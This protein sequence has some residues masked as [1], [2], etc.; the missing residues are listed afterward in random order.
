MH[1]NFKIESPS[2]SPI[3]P[4][5]CRSIFIHSLYH[6]HYP[7][8][9][10]QISQCPLNHLPRHP[11]KCFLHINKSHPQVFCARYFSCSCRTMMLLPAINAN[12]NFHNLSHPPFNYSFQNL[13]C[14]F[15]QLQLL[16]ILSDH[17]SMHTLLPMSIHCKN[18]KLG[19]IILY[20]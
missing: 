17:G 3:H 20:E 15:Y 12:V 18:K 1:P 2:L 8:I 10:T 11:I 4:H 14:M 6:W 13:Q 9:Y 16:I 5:F 7:F 19:L